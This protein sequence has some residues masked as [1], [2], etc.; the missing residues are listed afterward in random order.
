MKTVKSFLPYAFSIFGIIS[1]LW[2]LLADY[3]NSIKDTTKIAEIAL[4]NSQ[5]NS[6]AIEGANKRIVLIE[7]DM[8]SIKINIKENNGK[9]SFLHDRVNDF[10]TALNQSIEHVNKQLKSEIKQ[11]ADKREIARAVAQLSADID[12]NRAYIFGGGNFNEESKNKS[13]EYRDKVSALS[14]AASDSLYL[15]NLA[16]SPIETARTSISTNFEGRVGKLEAKL[17]SLTSRAPV[18]PPPRERKR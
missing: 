6:L 2:L 17:D 18:N 13:K 12:R 4:K 1:L 8:D 15:E 10:F 7:S 9:I 5:Q 14:K 11:K 16:I 3:G